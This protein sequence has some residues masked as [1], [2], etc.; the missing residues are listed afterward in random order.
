M[1]T[2]KKDLRFDPVLLDSMQE[3]LTVRV[4]KIKG[5]FRTPIDLPPRDENLAP[6]V[7]WDRDSVRKLE[8]WLVN[9]WA[10][11]G[12][13]NYT[14]A[15]PSGR[16]M[17]W[18]SLW[19]PRT[20]PERIPPTMMST[21]VPG[22]SIPP[23]QQPGMGMGNMNGSM[24]TPVGSWPLPPA[25]AYS[26]TLP[27]SQYPQQQPQQYQQPQYQ[28]QP[29]Q[30]QPQQY[31][32]PLQSPFGPTPFQNGFNPFGGNPW[33]QGQPNWQTSMRTPMP[34]HDDDRRRRR[35]ANDEDEE[36]KKEL[37]KQNKDLQERL[38]QIQ[39]DQLAAAHKAEM[40][41][42]RVEQERERDKQAQSHAAEL[43]SLKEELRRIAEVAAKPPVVP[44]IDPQVE[45][46]KEERERFERERE[47]DQLNKRF[48]EIL[49]STNK[50]FEDVIGAVGKAAERPTGPDP[51]IIA[52]QEQQKSLQEELRRERERVEMERRDRERSEAERREREALK[53]EMHRNEEQLRQQIAE[54]K[55]NRGPDPMYQV[56]QESTRAQIEAMKEMFRSQQANSDRLHGMMMSPRD[57]LAITKE[58]SSGIDSISKNIVGVY[59]DIFQTQRMLI[60]QAAQLTN[61]GESPT[62]RLVERGL[63]G[64][65]EM[66]DR[67]L[68]MKRDET[69]SHA[70]VQEA[71]VNAQ[72]AQ[73][74][75][76]GQAWAAQQANLTAMAAREQATAATAAAAVAA[77]AR[78]SNGSNGAYSNAGLGAT[79]FVVPEPTSPPKNGAKSPI[80]PSEAPQT[81]TKEPVKENATTTAGNFPPPIQNEGAKVIP[82]RRKGRTDEEWFGPALGHV[83]RLR[84]GVNEFLISLASIH[85]DGKGNV[86]VDPK[87]ITPEGNLIGVDPDNCVEMIMRAV[88]IV[89]GEQLNVRAF[90]ELFMQQRYA[91]FLEVLIP[92]A[93]EQYQSD[94]VKALAEIEAQHSSEED[95]DNSGEGD[96]EV[97]DQAEEH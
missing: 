36:M 81:P 20:Y 49:G 59:N 2:Q 51:A 41:R 17:E 80:P 24:A 86:I 55:T 25:A 60:E 37:E 52:M 96:P 39:R 74:N 66:A 63:D 21:V 84:Q 92:D 32:Q 13:Y 46:L 44:T 58:N 5:T 91:D 6:G 19:D 40:D 69:V 35:F 11:G 7:G 50:R 75:A 31:Q 90:D 23:P 57:I 27:T 8:T 65:K 72:A 85:D 53:T 68:R 16:K 78:S 26:Q 34:N 3:P 43:A 97:T 9:E 71:A 82:L 73:A 83:Q 15:D 93:P 29:Q 89:L 61:T 70:K 42:I 87:R 79:P 33:L 45:R 12:M 56:M 38:H 94:C 4:E 54:M 28:Q 62:M 30:Q 76:Q 14:V 48:E 1:S 47:R 95:D 64:A 88:N 18:Q 10:G 77:Q 67:Y 22:P